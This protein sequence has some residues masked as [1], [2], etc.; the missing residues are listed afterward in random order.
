MTAVRYEAHLG[1]RLGMVFVGV[2]ELLRYETLR[3]VIA[4]KFDVEIR[5]DMHIRASLVVVLLAADKLARLAFGFGI[6]VVRASK[7]LLHGCSVVDD[8]VFLVD[9]LH[10]DIRSKL[11]I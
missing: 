5:G 11:V 9:Y 6:A 8:L 4:G 1:N 3:L 7:L 2:N 10:F